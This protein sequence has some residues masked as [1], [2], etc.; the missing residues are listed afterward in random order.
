MNAYS[1]ALAGRSNRLLLRLRLSGQRRLNS[2]KPQDKAQDVPKATT[3][4]G[5]G[6]TW[7]EPLKEPFRAYG[8]MQYRSPYITQLSTTLIIY[9]L[10][11][12]SAQKVSS[13]EPYDPSR[14]LRALVIGGISSIPNY[15]W[16]MFLGNHFNYKSHAVSIAT[17]IVVNQTF[18]TPC[19]NTYFFGMQSLLS[20]QSLAQTKQRVMDTVP[21]WPAV[22]AF[23][24]TFVAPQYRSV[25]AGVIAI[26]WQTYLSWLNMKA[27]KEEDERAATSAAAAPV[28]APSTAVPAV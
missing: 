27:Q 1:F 28:T 26:G 6:M 18:F 10:G 8:R 17:K 13:D 4:P 23:S 14:G 7:I 12:L 2:T 21:L 20:G 25:F 3:I 22:T 11:D 16:F 19:F 9:F 5:P 15:K 24:F